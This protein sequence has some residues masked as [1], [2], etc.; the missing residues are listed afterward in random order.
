[1]YNLFIYFTPSVASILPPHRGQ[2]TLRNA[3][4]TNN[5]NAIKQNESRTPSRRVV[6]PDWSHLVL[7][8]LAVVAGTTDGGL[9]R[10]GPVAVN[11]PNNSVHWFRFHHVAA[12]AY[13]GDWLGYAGLRTR[14][15]GPTFAEATARVC[16]H[17]E[18]Y[19]AGYAYFSSVT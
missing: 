17:V 19:A 10:V 1:M 2:T 13:G 18:F 6:Q 7:L 12:L 5:Q 3:H 9:E 16:C 11:A 15:Y 4:H 14:R 8:L